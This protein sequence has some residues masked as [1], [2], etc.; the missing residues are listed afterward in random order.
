[1]AAKKYNCTNFAN[2]DAALTKEA[3]EIEDGE[4]LV[5]PSCQGAKTLVAAG[6][7]A[8]GGG[9]GFPKGLAIA[10]GALVLVVA[11]AWALWPSPPSPEMAAAMLNDFFPRL[12]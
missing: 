12:N 11:L 4:D 1:M 2:C 9:G 3:I 6:D 5:C 8:A 10:G 7:G